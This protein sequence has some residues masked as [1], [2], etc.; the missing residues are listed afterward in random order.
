LKKV[1]SQALTTVRLAFTLNQKKAQEIIA[2]QKDRMKQ[3]EQ[4]SQQ[5]FEALGGDQSATDY[6]MLM[7]LVNPGKFAASALK[8]TGE[9]AVSFAKQIGLGDISIATAKGEEKEEDAL[10]R[11]REQDG[12]VKKLLRNLEQIFFLAHAAPAGTVLVEDASLATIEDEI[13]AG[14]LGP[15]VKEQQAALADSL[16]ELTVLIESL[17]AQNAFLSVATRIDTAR[18]PLLGLAQME[19]AIARLRSQDAEAA[20][21]FE[22]LPRSIKAEA[23][24]LAKTDTFKRQTLENLTP[25]EAEHADLEKQALQAIMGATFGDAIS[26][27][28]TAIKENN[29]L[30][31]NTINDMFPSGKITVELLESLD[32]LSPGFSRSLRDA[33]KVLQKRIIS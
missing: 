5:V 20:K 18:N 2:R 21:Q 28:L 33:E 31:E 19:A 7:F 29:E 32:T 23:A 17:A 6:N 16:K 22:N 15:A 3:F 11:R 30:L 13:M 4:E 25:E 8:T 10:I 1:A 14:P 12:P 9:G 24:A 27:Y 26:D